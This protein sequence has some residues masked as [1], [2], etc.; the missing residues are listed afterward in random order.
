MANSEG[1]LEPDVAF[2]L[3]VKQRIL[4]RLRG[5]LTLRDTLRDL[6]AYRKQHHL[7]RSAARLEEMEA[8]LIRDGYTSFWR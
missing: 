8:R 1:L 5:T 3:Q 2:D 7:P 4:P 6:T